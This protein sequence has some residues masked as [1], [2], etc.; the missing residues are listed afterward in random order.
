MPT[1]LLLS[2]IGTPDILYFLVIIFISEIV[3][4]GDA[5]TGS[6][7]TP[8]SY[9]FTNLICL[10]CS[11]IDIFLCIIPMPPSPARVIAI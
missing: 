6:F 2:T 8:L 9:F 11:S 5:V 10:A 1:N 3:I 7:I 4:S